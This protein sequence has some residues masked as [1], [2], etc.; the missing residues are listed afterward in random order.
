MHAPS[1]PA[2]SASDRGHRLLLLGRL[3][4]AEDDHDRNRRARF[5]G[6]TGELLDA[7][8]ARWSRIGGALA[9]LARL[10]GE[11]CASSA[12]CEARPRA[13]LVA[14]RLSEAIDDQ[15]DREAWLVADAAARLAIGE[16]AGRCA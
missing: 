13:E 7:D 3:Q 10:I 8:K 14:A 4:E 11:A 6:V 9:T 5:A 1:P 16:G 15:I 2:R 12:F